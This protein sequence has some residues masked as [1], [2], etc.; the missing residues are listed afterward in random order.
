MAKIC[1]PRLKAAVTDSMKRR[2]LG[3]DDETESFRK[4]TFSKNLMFLSSFPFSTSLS[5]L[6]SPI[7][8]A[9]GVPYS[10]VTS[11]QGHRRKKVYSCSDP[12][13]SF[14]P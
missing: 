4:S 14:H 10:V 8:G 2:G 9:L 11:L 1:S 3:K 6:E 13:H 7:T 12:C 5:S